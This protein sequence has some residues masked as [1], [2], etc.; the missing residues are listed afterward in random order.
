MAEFEDDRRLFLEYIYEIGVE[1]PDLT[2]F[3][4]DYDNEVNRLI[5]SKVKERR[6]ELM[7]NNSKNINKNEAEKIELQEQMK[8]VNYISQNQWLLST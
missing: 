2:N 7:L 6:K 4:G 8:K 5:I 3:E 1:L